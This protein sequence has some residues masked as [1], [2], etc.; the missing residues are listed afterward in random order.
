MK[1]Q[2]LWLLLSLTAAVLCAGDI[3]FKNANFD[4]VFDTQGATIKKLIHNQVDWHAAGPKRQGNSFCDSRIGRAVEPKVQY[5]E[6]F[7]RLEYK[8]ASWKTY[9]T[10]G[11]ADVTF[12][13]KGTVYNWLR[14]NKTYQLR[15]GNLLEVVYEF[16]NTSDR[17][18]SFSFSP[19]WFFH[20]TDKE[21]FY[22][23]PTAK[24]IRKLK[25]QKSF[26]FV[27]TMLIQIYKAIPITAITVIA[28]LTFWVFVPVYSKVTVPS[29]TLPTFTRIRLKLP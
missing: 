14:L 18:Q 27:K 11:W 4:I 17:P 3:P 23:Q 28:P 26:F 12:S 16:T 22:W 20:R 9:K 15:T 10:S 5:N 6:N 24:G 29:R 8:L 19:R 21:N 25:Q 7:A 2:F 13:V 1:K